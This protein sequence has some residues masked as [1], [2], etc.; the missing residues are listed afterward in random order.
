MNTETS[1]CKLCS[2]SY[3]VKEIWRNY[4][5]DH[6]KTCWK[7]LKEWIDSCAQ[8]PYRVGAAIM[9]HEAPHIVDQ[10]LVDRFKTAYEVA[11]KLLNKS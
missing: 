2:S 11:F 5:S 1:I 10:T 8:D 9:R 4:G 7:C 3:D 6:K